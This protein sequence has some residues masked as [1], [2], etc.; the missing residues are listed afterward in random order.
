ML[1]SK[2]S[3]SIKHCDKLNE[4]ELNK[5]YDYL[6]GDKLIISNEEVLN[7]ILWEV[8][9]FRKIINKSILS[10]R[11]QKQKQKYNYVILDGH[12][13]I[14]CFFS[15][16][17][18]SNTETSK[19]KDMLD[20]LEYDKINIYE[21]FLLMHNNADINSIL[22]Y[23]IKV[24]SN[25]AN[26]GKIRKKLN[27]LTLYLD[28]KNTISHYIT[29]NNT[30]FEIALIDTISHKK[31]F[32]L[33][34]LTNIYN[35]TGNADINSHRDI[36]SINS[37][38]SKGQ[39]I[40]LL[41][42]LYGLNNIILPAQ[43]KKRVLTKKS[44]AIPKLSMVLKDINEMTELQNLPEYDYDITLLAFKYKSIVNYIVQNNF[45]LSKE[46][47]HKFIM[48]SFFG[49]ARIFN[50]DIYDIYYNIIENFI[51][52]YKCNV[53]DIKSKYFNLGFLLQKKYDDEL[54]YIDNAINENIFSKY[55]DNLYIS[56]IL[57]L[58]KK[59]N[60]KYSIIIPINNS[61]I[62]ERIEEIKKV[63]LKINIAKNY[64]DI[65]NNF[66]VINKKF[67]II[68]INLDYVNYDMLI[69]NINMIIKSGIIIS[70]ILNSLLYLNN[71]GKLVVMITHGYLSIPIYKKIFS[72][73]LELFES[74]E[75]IYIKNYY[76]KFE[77][78]FNNFK[79]LDHYKT[80]LV[81]KIITLVEE[82]EELDFKIEDI[83]FYLKTNKFTYKYKALNNIREDN[84]EEDYNKNKK[85]IRSNILFDIDGLNIKSSK[86]NEFYNKINKMM[87]T[88]KQ[89]SKYTNDNSCEILRKYYDDI[90]KCLFTFTEK[91]NIL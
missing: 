86:L 65:K 29:H 54:K 43:V 19:E 69:G 12:N 45:I 55:N 44:I 28:T 7:N 70:S 73:L 49:K 78:I 50:Q 85:N 24:F 41:L 1:D 3:F 20:N 88:E 84:K 80:N 60:N 36:S 63:D 61:K 18:L 31:P 77:V 66:M 47:I 76:Y 14:Q 6:T 33:Y 57:T 10:R 5:L 4:K 23:I 38:I 39:I 62:T 2:M 30:P 81:K 56:N 15:L 58:I 16:T 22:Q 51:K 90:Y 21:L 53:D 64:E 26:D 71:D 75:F 35:I 9:Y 91:Y 82:Y 52:K 17:K 11:S 27:I 42:E 72:L 59:L 40:T 74:Y 46:Q 8:I 68:K 25:L 79:G 48:N 34:Y 89:L 87:N 13:K 67:N 32:N 83:A 37:S